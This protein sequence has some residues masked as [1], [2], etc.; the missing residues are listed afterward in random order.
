MGQMYSWGLGFH[1]GSD[2]L[3][4]G[5]GLYCGVELYGVSDAS[6]GSIYTEANAFLRQMGLY[7]GQNH[8]CAAG[9]IW[10]IQY[11]TEGLGLSGDSM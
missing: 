4:R 8:Y 7:R 3:L 1:E 10:G 5:P 2:A 6:R 11:I 9:V